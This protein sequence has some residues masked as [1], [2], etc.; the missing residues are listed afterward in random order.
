MAGRKYAHRDSSATPLKRSL[1]GVLILSVVWFSNCSD[2]YKNQIPAP[3]LPDYQGIEQ[4]YWKV[5]QIMTLDV[6]KGTQANG[7]S[8]RYLN[9]ENELLIYQ[10]PTIMTALFGVYGCSEFPVM[11]SLDN[12]YLGQRSDGFI[13]RV[14][15]SVTGE[16]LHVPSVN[17]PMINPPLFTWAELKYYH[18]T[19]DK[20]RL[21]RYFPVFEKYF[22]WIDNSCRGK[23][24][25]SL[26][27]YN[28][29]IGSQMTNSPRNAN[30]LGGW[31][32]LSA[33][34]ALFAD[35]LATIAEILGEKSRVAIYQQRY[36]EIANEI[37]LK[38]WSQDD[39]FYYDM[40]SDGRNIRIKTTA[41]FWPL[42][43][44]IPD[45]AEARQLIDH[46]KDPGEFDRH[47]RFPTLAAKEDDF[48][49]G[50]AFWRGGVWSCENYMITEGLKKYG[51]YE[52]AAE[53][54]WNHITNMEKIFTGVVPDT[55][56][57]E[58][59][60]KSEATAAIWELY[61]SETDL[62]GTRWDTRY[63]CRS[64]YIATAG[65]GPVAMLIEDVLGF[66][67][68]GPSDQLTWRP[69]LLNKHGIRNLKFGNNLV[70]LWCEKRESKESPLVISG[71]TS[72]PFL[73]NIILG[74]DTVAIRQPRGRIKINLTMDNFQRVAEK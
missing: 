9:T 2:L 11:E 50:G 46:L 34:M 45:T 7:F 44:G 12:F 56:M 14:N 26:L 74:E 70:T 15:N 52:F 23:D 4:M 65:H 30:E 60:I 29:P 54:A 28:T 6:V 40:T 59:E 20:R 68:D 61:S 73:L 31:T 35:H 67:A 36:Q 58:G 43:A 69:W 62:P 17:E 33:Q 53:S 71:L 8:R 18:L 22:E 48:S 63:F 10:E 16:Y 41:G 25:A 3:I 37:R 47:H 1:L 24:E 42:I 39:A 5:W 49:A 19:G 13:S 55:T 66:S 38:L 21:K 51:E 64:N 57:I 27:Y 32:D 72:S